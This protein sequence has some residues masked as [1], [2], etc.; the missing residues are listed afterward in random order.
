MRCLN[1]GI[2]LKGNVS[3]SYILVEHRVRIFKV[4]ANENIFPLSSYDC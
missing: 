2:I 3:S 4:V 1:S